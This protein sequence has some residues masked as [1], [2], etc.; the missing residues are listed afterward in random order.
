MVRKREFQKNYVDYWNSTAELTQSK[1]PADAF[2]M[3]VAH[4]PAALPGKYDGYTYTLPINALDFTS[5]VVPVTTAKKD[6]DVVKGEH[7]PL[8]ALDTNFANC[9]LHLDDWGAT[10]ANSDIRRSRDIRRRLRWSPDCVQALT[11]RKG[12]GN[13]GVR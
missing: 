12:A 5:V 4:L 8:S 7:T 10:H 9:E 1:R 3:P 6:I 13:C 2:I 11:G